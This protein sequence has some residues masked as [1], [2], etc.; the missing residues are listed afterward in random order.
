MSLLVV[1][2]VAFDSVETPFGARDDVLG[3]SASFFSTSA[4]FFCPVRMV[5]VIGQDF[6]GE[7]LQAF[8][9]RGIDT[10]GVERQSGKTFRW[11]GRY[12]HNLNV[13]HTLET[14]LNVLSTFDPK[15]PASYGSSEHVFLGNFDPVLQRKV[16]EQLARPKLVALDTMNFWIEGHNAELRRTLKMVDL[17]S[18]NDGEA[19]LLSGEYHLRKAA[20]AIRAM[21]PK[22][23]VVKRGEYGAI[24][25]TEE[26]VFVAP[27]YPLEVIR[28][29]TGA[30]DSFAG[31]LMGFVARNGS[32]GAQTLRQAII[33]GSVMASFAVEDFSLERFKTLTQDEIRLRF[34]EFKALTHFEAEGIPIWDAE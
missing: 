13:A 23:L 22:Y 30:G 25:F 6:P 29:P 20:V 12:D 33:T 34:R 31:G 1:G 4:S 16:L 15:L 32:F 2:T 17:L 27:A 9:Q 18:I 24:L 5:S 7:H 19:R 3:G 14:Q 21:G 28:D 11:R 26:G 10:E 8:E